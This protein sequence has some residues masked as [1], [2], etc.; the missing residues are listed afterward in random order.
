[1][2][3]TASLLNGL[4][5]AAGADGL[6]TDPARTAPMLRDHRA[7]YRG[8]ALAVPK[9]DVTA[10]VAMTYT[11]TGATADHTH[12]VTISAS[13]FAMLASNTTVMTVSTTTNNHTHNVTVSC[14]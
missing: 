9:A 13:A 8:H 5:A 12:N 11:T 14:A 3:D 1:M 6:I 4:A 10:G 7:L 2:N